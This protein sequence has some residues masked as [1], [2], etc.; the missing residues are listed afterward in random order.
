MEN[1]AREG[2]RRAVVALREIV[3]GGI[4]KVDRLTG[5]DE[6]R[7]QLAIQGLQPGARLRL[8]QK[9]GRGHRGIVVICGE[10]RLA[11]GRKEADGILVEPDVTDGHGVLGAD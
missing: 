11:L 2:T 8:L 3:P 9:G 4:C 10:T 7:R 5:S 6:V 1:K